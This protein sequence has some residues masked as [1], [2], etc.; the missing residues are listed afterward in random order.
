MVSSDVPEK[1]TNK[2]HLQQ[3]ANEEDINIQDTQN[4]KHRDL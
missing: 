1:L 3:E 2:F 4:I